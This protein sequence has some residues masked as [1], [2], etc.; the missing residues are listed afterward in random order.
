MYRRTF[1]GLVLFFLVS[2]LCIWSIW[3]PAAKIKL[4]L[5]LKGGTLLVYRLDMSSVPAGEQS[6]VADEVK[7][8]VYQRL[9]RYGLKEIEVRRV[10]NDRLQV[11]VPS[12]S[13]DEINTLKDQ[14]SK[15]G[16]LTLY[17]ADDEFVAK[18]PTQEKIEEIQ[19][20]WE[21]YRRAMEAWNQRVAQLGPQ[22]AGERPA[23]PARVAC[24]EY[25]EDKKTSERVVDPTTGAFVVQRW[26]ILH[27]E[28]DL[29]IPGNLI[30]SAKR[31]VNHE[32]H[33]PAVSFEFQASGAQK[34][35]AV[36]KDNI[37]KHLAIVLDEVVLSAPTIRAHLS[38]GGGI[39]TGSFT[40]SQATGLANILSVGSMP[41]SPTL[42]QEQT[43]GARLG[44][45]QI[46]HGQYA[47]VMGFILVVA[48]MAFYYKGLGVVA[49]I[50]LL[51]NLI[52]VLAYVAM[53]RQSLSFPGI[54]GLLLSVGMAVD[55][56]ILIF[57]RIRE[58]FRKEKGLD[59]TIAAGFNRAFWTIFDSNVTTIITGVVLF[60]VGTGPIQGFAI[61]LIAGLLANFVTAIY[62]SRLLISVFHKLGLLRKFS[63]RE[64]KA[65]R[66][67]KVPFVNLQRFFVPTS[68]IILVLGAA[69]VAWRGKESVGIDFRGGTEINITLSEAEDITDFR[70][71]LDG[72]TD[73]G[74]KLFVETQVQ[75]SLGT[76]DGKYRGFLVRVP[77]KEAVKPV[78][79]EPVPAEPAPVAPA[80]VAPEAVAPEAV[81]P[82]AVAPEAPPA[83]PALNAPAAPAVPPVPT[84]PEAPDAPATPTPGAPPEDAPATTTSGTSA[85]PGEEHVSAPSVATPQKPE[86]RY[87]R[88]LERVF[89]GKLAP[90]SFPLAEERAHPLNPDL[91]VLVLRVNMYTGDP[92]VREGGQA[93]G[94]KMPSPA[95]P[96]QLGFAQE[97][98]GLLDQYLAAERQAA[99][100]RPG[101]TSIGKFEIA[102][103]TLLEDTVTPAFG[104]YEIMTAPIKYGESGAPTGGE[105]VLTVLRAF[106][107]SDFYRL[108]M[109]LPAHEAYHQFFVS[110]PIPSVS[111]VDSAVASDFQ[112]S[113]M[114][115][116]LMSFLAMLFY[117][118]IRFEFAYGVGALVAIV[119]D[120][121][122]G[123]VVLVLVD[124]LFGSFF[125]VKID[126]QVIAGL[127]TLI[128]F[129]INDTIVI[130]DRVRENLSRDRKAAFEDVVNA[131]INQTLARTV[132]TTLT[133]FLTVVVLLI[134]GGE[135]VRSFTTCMLAG[136]IFGTYSS[137]FIAG[138]VTIYM[139]R[140]K[141]RRREERVQEA[142]GA[143]RPA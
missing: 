93:E 85:A 96:L 97:L 143:R 107:S 90:P 121:I 43:I 95:T 9:D 25:E 8:V 129:S 100:T 29:R 24:V 36:T 65:L 73:G 10:G 49:N 15:A 79:A 3:P 57:E 48:F 128:G 130:F 102:D 137:I 28:P 134:W 140:R 72:I 135:S 13:P 109:M 44:K 55:A 123:V 122:M 126:L 19:A 98:K 108:Q 17:L 142:M 35:S 33:S 87:R 62:L 119:H 138:P 64:I 42:V 116:V 11:A 111:F 20:Q 27:N 47:V 82:E 103:V 117:L 86:E 113:A 81:A 16:N 31:S 131:S 71:T 139:R 53:F 76:P 141:E 67:P 50:A 63:M 91:K 61:T 112:G 30:R 32:D 18:P 120:V 106:F 74:E 101:R 70:K 92:E 58:E 1:S 84:A 110:E 41:T 59:Q 94:A 2:G 34:L 22:A 54:A 23:E 38:E 88:A 26:W 114:L 60:H 37:G 115:A 136:L 83:A 132:Q 69:F 56:N 21:T 6:S 66:D 40:Q 51:T 105:Q 46:A 127:L 89:A 99:G 133:V 78:P 80:P 75:A 77:Y 5:D 125:S 4:G 45:D 39:I 118:G 124:F 7:K 68:M 52:V 12:V 14:V 104:T